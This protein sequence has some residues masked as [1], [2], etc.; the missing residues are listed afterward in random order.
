VALRDRLRVELARQSGEPTTL[1]ELELSWWYDHAAEPFPKGILRVP[2]SGLVAKGVDP[3]TLGCLTAAVVHDFSPDRRVWYV[4]F[5]DD[6]DPVDVIRSDRRPVHRDVLH[7]SGGWR[8]LGYDVMKVRGARPRRRAG[9]R[10]AAWRILLSARSRCRASRR[11]ERQ[12][13]P[14]RDRRT[15]ARRRS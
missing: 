1:G 4:A 14:E 15:V 2:L 3:A 13:D 12:G 7:Q 5:F 9:E 10:Q 8:A 11:G 6:V